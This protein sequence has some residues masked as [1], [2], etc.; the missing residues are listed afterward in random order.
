M[1]VIE[2]KMAKNICNEAYFSSGYILRKNLSKYLAYSSI[3]I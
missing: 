1:A 3:L 2:E